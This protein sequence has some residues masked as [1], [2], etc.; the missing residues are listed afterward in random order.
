MKKAI[1]TPQLRDVKRRGFKLEYNGKM[2]SV[3]QLSKETGIS[4]HLI[5]K[6]IDEGKT[7]EEI[8]EKPYTNTKV[9]EIKKGLCTRHEINQMAKDSSL[10]YNTIGKRLF[11]GWSI[12]EALNTPVLPGVRREMRFR[13]MYK[14]KDY[15]M[16]E[17]SQL[18]ECVVSADLL[19]SR[20][21]NGGWDV[22]K[23]ITTKPLSGAERMQMAREKG[24]LLGRTAKKY[25]YKGKEYTL[26][27]L[28]ALPECEVQQYNTLCSRI[29]QRGLSVE[30]A[31]KV[32]RGE[33]YRYHGKLLTVSELAKLPEC[34]VCVKTLRDRLRNGMAVEKAL[35]LPREGKTYEYKGRYYSI[36]ELA[37]LPECKVQQQVLYKRL[38]TECA[39]EAISRLPDRSGP[40]G[41]K[42]YRY[43]G[44]SYT[45]TELAAMPEC[46][47]SMPALYARL[48]K[49]DSVEGA[50]GA[51]RKR[52]CKAKK[53]S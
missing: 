17:L 23:A 34:K 22:E 3:S 46:Q 32:K 37:E 36:K 7:V 39:E 28:L 9:Y 4:T 48:K 35:T 49:G 16:K 14:G 19:T 42:V 43:N 20:I 40:K 33:K 11:D 1:N 8:I 41:N 53:T 31:L 51:L 24:M 27:E 26:R 50:M 15:T 18:P 13:V 30:E 6:R 52:G 44:A 21:K 47:V 10:S 5:W 2:V 38:K 12:E 29:N 25:T 45:V